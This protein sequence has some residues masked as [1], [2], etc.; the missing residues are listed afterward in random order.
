MKMKEVCTRTGLS[1][2]AVR[3]YC[4]Q[5]LLTPEK[6]EVRGRVYLDF[7]EADI[8]G[9]EQI[10][11]LRGIGLSL[12]EIKAALQNPGA[13]AS[14][15]DGLRQRLETEQGEQNRV[16]ELLDGISAGTPPDS[17][18][19]LCRALASDEKPRPYTNGAVLRDDGPSFREFCAQ[20]EYADD[21]YTILDYNIDRG[22]I[23]MA[24]FRVLYWLSAGLNLFTNLA[25]GALFGG[26]VVFAV[27]LVLYIYL[28]RGV[29]WIR[30][31][32]AIFSAFEAFFCFAMAA[33]SWPSV[34]Q[35]WMTGKSGTQQLLAPTGSWIGVVIFCV[36][37]LIYVAVTYFLG[38]NAWVSDYLYDQ[39]TKY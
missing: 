26:L 9:L 27:Q 1:E 35:V 39:S 32:M 8:T 36:I 4:E 13:I 3:L 5:G 20:S 31:M 21:T 18:D 25:N 17:V 33:D 2:R 34:R 22:R 19:A 24:V 29:V 11:A 14:L 7:D 30:V 12:E 10:A 6:T 16:L 28:F 38:F 23:V 15:L 37:G